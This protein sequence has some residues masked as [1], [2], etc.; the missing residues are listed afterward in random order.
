MLPA[1]RCR[2]GSWGL[3]PSL[4]HD[5]PSLVDE[6][7]RSPESSSFSTVANRLFAADVVEEN[8]RYVIHFDAPGIKE[9]EVE[10]S[11]DGSE[12]LISIERKQ[13]SVSEEGK[14]LHQSRWHGATSRRISLPEGTVKEDG[15]HAYLKDGVLTLEIDKAE[16]R[17]ARKIQVTSK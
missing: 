16:E 12:L 3:F 14:F 9:D 5:W 8:N 4:F 13:S 10:V 2:T 1:K 11:L 17:Q 7:G 15:I 6:I